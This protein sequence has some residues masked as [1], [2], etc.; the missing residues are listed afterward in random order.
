[1]NLSRGRVMPLV[2][3]I[4]SAT[5]G[6]GP[7]EAVD[8]AAIV[9]RFEARPASIPPGGSAELSWSANDI[10]ASVRI[11]AGECPERQVGPEG[12]VSMGPPCAGEVVVGAEVSSSGTLRVTPAEST[13][14]WCFPYRARAAAFAF[15]RTVNV[16]VTP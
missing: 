4:G 3:A 13:T 8:P 2:L 10:V 7:E 14:Y 9:T 16:A 12:H 6:G 15:G 11:T 1:V 5:C